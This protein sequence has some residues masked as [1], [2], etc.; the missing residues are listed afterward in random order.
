MSIFVPRPGLL[1]IIITPTKSGHCLKLYCLFIDIF[2]TEHIHS[3]M[4]LMFLR[5]LTIIQDAL[6]VEAHTHPV[7]KRT[8][9]AV[10]R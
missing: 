3:A 7:F 9:F 2:D 6:F 8:V 10:A 5:G 1:S 4:N